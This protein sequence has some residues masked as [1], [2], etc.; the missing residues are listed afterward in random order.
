MQKTL[1][2]GRVLRPGQR[3]ILFSL[4]DGRAECF[5]KTASRVTLP[6]AI[7]ENPADFRAPVLETLLQRLSRRVPVQLPACY[8]SVNPAKKIVCIRHRLAERR[9]FCLYRLRV[10]LKGFEYKTRKA[11]QRPANYRDGT[12]SGLYPGYN[13]KAFELR[14]DSRPAATA[15]A[16]WRIVGKETRLS[17][18]VH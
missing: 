10:M 9:L 16:A 5:F 12:Q 18:A 15:P 7:L 2:A 8:R 17:R 1:S 3:V 13:A 11:R 6:A 4:F 14:T